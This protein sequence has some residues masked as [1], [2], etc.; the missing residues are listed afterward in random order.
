MGR[1]GYLA[2]HLYVTEVFRAQNDLAPHPISPDNATHS[3][4]ASKCRRVNGQETA[5]CQDVNQNAKCSPT[6]V[7]C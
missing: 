6:W 7:P 2:V 1:C 3:C 5:A 4:I